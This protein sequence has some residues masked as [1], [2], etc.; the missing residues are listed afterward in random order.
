[1][2]VLQPVPYICVMKISIVTET[3]CVSDRHCHL[4]L[5]LSLTVLGTQIVVTLAI[6]SSEEPGCVTHIEMA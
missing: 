6:L 1:M 5:S 4:D 2:S 3:E